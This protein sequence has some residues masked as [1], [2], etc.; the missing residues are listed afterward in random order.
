MSASIKRLPR[1]FPEFEQLFSARATPRAENFSSRYEIEVES[2]NQKWYGRLQNPK[3]ATFIAVLA[4]KF[5][6]E[7]ERP[8]TENWIG[9][10]VVMGPFLPVD[11]ARGIEVV[12]TVIT[13]DKEAESLRVFVVNSVCAQELP[14]EKDRRIIAWG[15]NE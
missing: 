3:A 7:G 5:D 2:L 8:D 1:S 15:G 12:E 10:A 6:V 4:S 14:R 9:M 11:A 13:D